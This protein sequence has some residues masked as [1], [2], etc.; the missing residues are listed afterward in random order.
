M[1]NSSHHDLYL[2]ILCPMS[3]AIW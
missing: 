3:L 2:N 1:M